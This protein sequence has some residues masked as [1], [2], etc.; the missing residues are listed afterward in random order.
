MGSLPGHGSVLPTGEYQYELPIEVPPGR[1]GMQPNL[2]LVYSSN[3]E[4][5]PLGMGWSISGLQ[6]IQ[7][8]AR[9][10]ASP[11]PGGRHQAHPIEFTADDALC[12]NNRRLV[13]IASNA[14]TKEYR[15]EED[16]FAKIEAHVTDGAIDSFSVHTKSGRTLDFSNAI[17]GETLHAFPLVRETDVS[18]NSIE[19]AYDV[20]VV[21]ATSGAAFRVEDYAISAIHYTSRTGEPG[22]RTVNFTYE[23]TSRP[24][25]LVRYW[26]SRKFSPGA[27]IQTQSA[28]RLV[29]IECWAPYPTTVALAWS[30]N[31]QYTTSA[32][33][34]SLLTDVRRVG[35]YGGRTLAKQFT[36]HSAT[37]A[38]FEQARYA[39]GAPLRV[40]EM[41][42][43][44]AQSVV[45]ADFDDD[46]RDD[47]LGAKLYRT[48]ESQLPLNA[49]AV[50]DARRD[51]NARV[52]DLDGDGVI[53][54]IDLATGDD[55]HTF[56][57]LHWDPDT[58]KIS[59]FG[60][61]ATG[62]L[63]QYI[64][65]E[66]P[67]GLTPLHPIDLDG[68]GLP[69]L[70]AGWHDNSLLDCNHSY[71]DERFESDCFN[72]HWTVLRNSPSGWSDQALTALGIA[73]PLTG[74]M[75]Y[76]AWAFAD[77]S[78]RAG[79]CA[80]RASGAGWLVPF[81]LR[82]TDEVDAGGAGV[83]GAERA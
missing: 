20:H 57:R 32:T 73:R 80:T 4:N 41:L 74:S 39:T 23:H 47:V 63:E 52:S 35:H 13:E 9:P 38:A 31:F 3:G 34:R 16:I 61:V 46:G 75:P 5:G 59:S 28:Y 45:V 6:T 21:P 33:G 54:L 65:H 58:Q 67:G 82:Q 70:V 77:G 24:D 50:S 1:A 66:T 43:S 2:A 71:I 7:A 22:S 62:N 12:W 81:T 83:C 27:G 11:A 51:R 19:Y 68:D 48:T 36:W 30:Y 72:W 78:G 53:D 17:G 25:P 69:E 8:C 56:K 44:E 49:V 37:G 29:A 42:P 60:P 18:G 40:P 14:D 64:V 15:T 76:T 79:L 10:Y 26:A 55:G